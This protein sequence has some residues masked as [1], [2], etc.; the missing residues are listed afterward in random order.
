MIED[1]YQKEKGIEYHSSVH[2]FPPEALDWISQKRKEKIQQ[3]IKE[4]SSVLEYGSG[5]GFN[6]RSLVAK[7]K[8]AYDIASHVNTYYKNSDVNF[9]SNLTS[10][11]SEKFD[12]I[13]CHHVLEHVPSPNATLNEIHELLKEDGTILLYIP[14]E[15]SRRF[16]KINPNDKDHHIYSWNIQTISNLVSLSGFKIISISKKR[17]GYDFIASRSAKKLG[18]GELFYKLFRS[19]FNIIRPV[20]EIEVVASKTNSST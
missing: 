18:L 20:Y 15:C 8:F 17:F 13:I 19:F 4:D 10:L 6:I 16:N 3:H 2:N 9:V 12:H 11:P 5:I 14:M 7:H 1:I